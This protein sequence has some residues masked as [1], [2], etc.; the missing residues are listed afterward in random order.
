MNRR[1]LKPVSAAIA[2]SLVVGCAGMPKEQIGTMAGAV[3]GGV[4]GKKLGGNTGAAVGAALGGLLGNR[5]GAL[6]DEQDKKKLEE[7]EQRALTTGR[8]GSF[9]ADKS[10]ATVSVEA[11]APT[12][13]TKKSF[14]LS[15]ELTAYPIVLV[16]SQDFLAYVDTPLFATLDQSSTPRML[17]PKGTKLRVS[18]N[19]VN[20]A[21]AV[22]GDSNVGIGYVPL[23]YLKPDI[24][25]DATRY[26]APPAV[27]KQEPPQKIARAD[28]GTATGKTTSPPRADASKANEK[29]AQPKPPVPV[30]KADQFE[31]EV[32]RL[33][34]AAPTEASAPRAAGGANST[35]PSSPGRLVQASIECKVISRKVDAD[36]N[37]GGGFTETIKYCKEPPKGWQT[38]AA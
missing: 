19:V 24:A 36:T 11:S 33:K 9:V 3:A 16:D 22:V 32:V 37:Q 23:R 12:L 29:I 34:S 26:G 1:Y 2:L 18:A 14:L 31:R 13:E 20:Q 27:V 6:L 5:L 7:L 35:T 8:G 21:W 25:M 30:A 4:I 17:V 28:A 15:N 10:K 38:Q